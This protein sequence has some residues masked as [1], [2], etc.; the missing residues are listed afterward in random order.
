MNNE[1]FV[2]K[3]KK[4]EKINLEYKESPV[5]FLSYIFNVILS[6]S[7]AF[8]AYGLVKDLGVDGHWL[9][10]TIIVL[11]ILTVCMFF[12]GSFFTISKFDAKWGLTW[13]LESY[14]Y[15]GD[16]KNIFDFSV[17]EINQVLKGMDKKIQASIIKNKGLR[18]SDILFI[19]EKITPFTDKI[20]AELKEKEEMI[21]QEEIKKTL[22]EA[23]TLSGKMLKDF[24][25]SINI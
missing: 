21:Q 4:L 6:V 24:E 10:L 17:P 2:V 9:V 5:I 20:A 8:Y 19:Q 16:L 18:G 23:Q 15:T 1:E 13:E 3:L 14:V 12:M 7:L 25:D 11:I 22:I